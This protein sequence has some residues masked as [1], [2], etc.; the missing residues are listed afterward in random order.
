MNQRDFRTSH[1]YYEYKME[2]RK[3]VSMDINAVSVARSKQDRIDRLSVEYQT[4]VD[5][6]VIACRGLTEP[7]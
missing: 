3:L 6:I 2:I 5:H 4:I 1:T 7:R